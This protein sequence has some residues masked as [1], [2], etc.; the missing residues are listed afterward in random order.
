[1][2][3]RERLESATDALAAEPWLALGPDG[4]ARLTELGRALSRQAIAAGAFPPGV[5]A[6]R[7]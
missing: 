6:A 7:R 5:F 4:T 1:V 2:A 3:L